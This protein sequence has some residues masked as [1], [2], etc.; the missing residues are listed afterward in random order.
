MIIT[1]YNFQLIKMRNGNRRNETKKDLRC[2]IPTM[3]LQASPVWDGVLPCTEWV[4]VSNAVNMFPCT[5]MLMIILLIFF[6]L[7]HVHCGFSSPAFPCRLRRLF[8]PRRLSA[9]VSLNKLHD[10]TI[11]SIKIQ[12]QLTWFSAVETVNGERN[13]FPFPVY[14]DQVNAT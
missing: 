11:C 1:S 13:V 3:E 12:M 4:N 2:K 5:L 7:F 14:V 10:E 6:H 8:A 9:R